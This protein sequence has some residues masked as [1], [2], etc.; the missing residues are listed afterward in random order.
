[1]FS[2]NIKGKENPKTPELVKLE[3]VLFKTGYPRVSKVIAIVGPLKEWDAKKQQFSGRGVEF[4]ERNKRLLEIKSSYLKVAEEW[5]AE[6]KD[7]SPV[8]WSHCFDVTKREK[9]KK[10]VLSVM[11]VCD[12]MIEHKFNNE[13]IKNGK[14]VS[15]ANTGRRY[16]C[17]KRALANF[18]NDKYGRKL[19]SYYFTDVTQQF[20]EDFVVYRKKLAITKGTS[21]DISTILR[22]LYGICQ[23]AIKLNVPDVDLTVFESTRQHSRSKKYEP[24]SI[25]RETMAKIESIDRTLLTRVEKFY[26]DL[27]LFSYYT[28]GMA[29]TDVAHLTWDCV[30]KEGYIN[31]ERMKYTKSAKIKLNS[32][33]QEI[34]DMHQ[35]KCFGNYVLPIFTHKHQ[36]EL[37]HDWRLKR[38]GRCVNLLLR[39]ICQIIKYDEKITWYSARGTFI[40]EMI[41]SDIHP[42]DVAA[43][44]GNSPQTIYKHYYKNVDQKEVDAKM[45]RALG[46]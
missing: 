14:I 37:Q 39:K 29:G 16:Q 6:D 10:K 25:S 44:A 19:E 9:A 31:Y 11:A 36:T 21:G 1:M 18:V 12:D 23:R 15:S 26:L 46:C 33:A 28:G 34:I 4:T 40:S 17:L 7:W 27:F 45:Q 35:D 24:R 38:V 20:I 5:E 32:K 43:M 13:R 8:Q 30:D 42:I 41:A 3:M 2:I 22:A